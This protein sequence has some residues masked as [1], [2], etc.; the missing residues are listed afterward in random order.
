MKEYTNYEFY[1]N[2]YKGIMP[3]SDFDRLVIR[4][5]TEV[6]NAI[7]NRDISGYEEEV[8]LATCSVADILLKIEQIENKK[9][10]L[11]SSEK[12]D[13]ILAS[14]Q[15]ADVS[16]TFAN[17]TKIADLDLEISNQ[18]SK[19]REEIEKNLLWTGLLNRSVSIDGRYI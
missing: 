1:E 2:T 16:R 14:E 8:Q 18:Q 6:R 15:V 13:R 12:E 10:K 7:M 19:I 9:S 3:K 17:T 5:S 4:A 11:V